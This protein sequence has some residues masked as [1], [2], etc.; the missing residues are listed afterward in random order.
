MSEAVKCLHVMKMKKAIE[1]LGTFLNDGWGAYL[2]I[3]N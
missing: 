2:I 3:E 1:H